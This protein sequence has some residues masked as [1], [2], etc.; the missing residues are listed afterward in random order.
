[1][2]KVS[3]AFESLYIIGKLKKIIQHI[4]NKTLKKVNITLEATEEGYYNDFHI[5]LKEE[6][7]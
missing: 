1:M 7:K 6:K 4:K 3:Y 5:E 2:K